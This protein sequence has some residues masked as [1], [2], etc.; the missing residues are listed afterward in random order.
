MKKFLLFLILSP[1]VFAQSIPEP[2][3]N[4]GIYSFLENL[5]FK[6]IISL[7]ENIKPFSRDFIANKLTEI[8]ESRITSLE[9]EYLEFYKKEFYYELNRISAFYDPALRT[10]V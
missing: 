1:V 6:G 4:T 8:D 7:N 5:S 10:T 2:V 3:Y 9:K